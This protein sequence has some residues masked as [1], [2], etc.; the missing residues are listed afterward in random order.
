MNDDRV[1]RLFREELLNVLQQKY[2]S[3]PY[4]LFF[5]SIES[6]LYALARCCNSSTFMGDDIED[7]D[8]RYLYVTPNGFCHDIHDLLT[9]A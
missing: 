7:I 9:Y 5:P 3:T 6:F 4:L 1:V 8:P 2:A